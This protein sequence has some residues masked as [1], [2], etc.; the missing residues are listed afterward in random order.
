VRRYAVTDAARH[1]SQEFDAVLDETNTARDVWADSAY[2]SR[3]PR[4]S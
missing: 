4:R 1:D 3:R 2:R